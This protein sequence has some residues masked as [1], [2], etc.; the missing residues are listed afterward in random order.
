MKAGW[1][2]K[3]L[4]SR[5]RS[6]QIENTTNEM[7]ALSIKNKNLFSE[8]IKINEGQWKSL[9]S[10]DNILRF[11]DIPW[12]NKDILKKIKVQKEIKKKLLLRWHPDRFF[13]S[14]I[15]SRIHPDDVEKVKS[16]VNEM[17]EL[18]VAITSF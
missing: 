14:K 18:I 15:W 1:Y 3:K 9:E 12:F 6:Y 17:C 8:L 4:N 2:E 11:D 16:N 10:T 13:S 5:W 7:K